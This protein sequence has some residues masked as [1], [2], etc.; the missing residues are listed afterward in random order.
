[1][2]FTYDFPASSVMYIFH[3]LLFH[4][5]KSGDRSILSPLCRVVDYR[6]F[7]HYGGKFNY[8]EIYGMHLVEV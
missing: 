1:M 2:L 6:M 5:S 7:M 4:E 8:V 3:V